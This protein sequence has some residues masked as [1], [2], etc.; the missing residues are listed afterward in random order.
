[1]RQRVGEEYDVTTL[2]LINDWSVQSRT[3]HTYV[4]LLC[5]RLFF[6]CRRILC[7]ES[8][9]SGLSPQKAVQAIFKALVPACGLFTDGTVI[10]PLLSTGN[11]VGRAMLYLQ[12]STTKVLVLPLFSHHFKQ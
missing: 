7:F 10:S 9:R 5:W 6:V 12:Y 1:M 8:S 3:V 2:A 11:Q 4:V